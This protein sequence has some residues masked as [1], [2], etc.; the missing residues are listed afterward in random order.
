ME[1]CWRVLRRMIWP[2]FCFTKITLAPGLNISWRWEEDSSRG[3]SYCTDLGKSW[4]ALTKEVA[5]EVVRSSQ[6]LSW[7]WRLSQQDSWET[8]CKVWERKVRD[9]SKTFWPEQ[10][11]GWAEMLHQL[12]WSSQKEWD[13]WWKCWMCS[14]IQVEIIS[15]QVDYKSWVQ[16]EVGTGDINLEVPGI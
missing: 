13:L 2:D 16:C 9:G 11:K 14:Y 7:Y 10:L 5:V 6:I 8:R 4:E 12:K 3:A 1:S 15:R